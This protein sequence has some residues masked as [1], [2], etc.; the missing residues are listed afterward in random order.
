M[1]MKIVLSGGGTGGHIYPALAILKEVQRQEPDSQF[2]FIGTA[3]G[4]ESELVPKAGIPFKSIEISGF[5]RK[6]TLENLKVIQQFIKSTYLAKKMLR[7]FQPD[8]VVGTGG[9]VCGPVVYAAHRLGIPTMI[10]EQNVIPG[11][12]NRFLA[13]YVDRIAISLEGVRGYFPKKKVVLTGNPRASEVVSVQNSEGK[14]ELNIPIPPERRIVLIVGGSRGARPINEAAVQMIPYMVMHP[15]LH[16]ILQT[17]DANYSMVEKLIKDEQL[18]IPENLT[19]LPYIYQM[20]E[21]LARTSCIINRAGASTIAEITALGI[22][23]ILIPSP[24]VTNNHQE[25]NAVWLE[26]AGASIMILEPHLT[27]TLLFDTVLQIM[28]NPTCMETMSIAAKK[29][30]I[31]DASQRF[32]LEMM[33]L[34]PK[35]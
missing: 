18:T 14:E 28:N 3:K 31:P 1:K 35:R 21:L 16:F 19:I 11:V 32:Y 10:H 4:L 13:R 20:P 17:G 15:D 26:E 7:E 8:V 6:L 34:L 23:S 24:Y 30:G 27:G 33:K 2:L 12:T 22:P 29:L 25:K 9:Y 5:K